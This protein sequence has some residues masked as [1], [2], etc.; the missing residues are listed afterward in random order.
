MMKPLVNFPCNACTNGHHKPGT[1][2]MRDEEGNM[3]DVYTPGCTAQ[4]I[5]DEGFTEN[6]EA[7]CSCLRN[8]HEK[9]RDG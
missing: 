3:R 6:P 5:A 1:Y 8:G 4:V 7:H 9:L 2:Q